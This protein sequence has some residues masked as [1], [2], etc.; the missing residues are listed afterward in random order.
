MWLIGAV[1]FALILAVIVTIILVLK[2][3]LGE[4]FTSEPKLIEF[5]LIFVPPVISR[6]TIL[7]SL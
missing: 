3:Y 5:F 4:G 2:M 6:L 1:L 7:T